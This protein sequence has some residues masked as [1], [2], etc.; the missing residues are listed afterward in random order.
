MPQ[1]CPNCASDT[2]ASVVEP[3]PEYGTGTT[4]YK[5]DVSLSSRAPLDPE[6]SNSF[7]P[8]PE[9]DDTQSPMALTSEV[10][11]TH[12]PAA[13]NG[14]SE[15]VYDDV[16]LSQSSHQGVTPKVPRRVTDRRHAPRRGHHRN[17]YE[18]VFLH[19]LTESLRRR[20]VPRK[21]S[22]RHRRSSAREKR[23][24]PRRG[25]ESSAE[26]NRVTSLK[27][28]EGESRGV[29]ERSML[30]PNTNV[31]QHEN[32]YAKANKGRRS[33]H[34]G[35]NSRTSSN[36]MVLENQLYDEE[37]RST[38]IQMARTDL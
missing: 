21:F 7:T 1:E 25:T 26:E 38:Q 28:E 32:G 14:R 9:Y 6:D 30:R 16:Y 35:D 29:V 19:S 31:V 18:N 8:E 36:I 23:L 4:L 27:E 37:I 17:V 10:V 22:S 33:S 34:G 13:A 2:Y 5:T 3:D 20:L 15:A 24:R 11:E 12:V